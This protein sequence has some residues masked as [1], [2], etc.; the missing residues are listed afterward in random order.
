MATTTLT[1]R[2]ALAGAEDLNWDDKGDGGSA[3]VSNSD[4]SYRTI[5]R[6]NASHLPVTAATRAKTTADGTTMTSGDVDTALQEIYDDLAAIGIPD[7]TILEVASG[8]LQIAANSIT[9]TQLAVECI[10]SDQY[11]D[12]SI[13]TAHFAAGAV[14][15]T[16]LG[17]NAVTNTKIA[18]GAVD[19]DE[20]AAGAVTKDKIAD[21]AVD[22]DSLDM[23]GNG[24]APSHYVVACEEIAS[25]T[26]ST[27]LAFTTAAT[28]QSSDIFLVTVKSFGTGPNYVK[29][30]NYT[31]V[32]SFT[33]DV[34][35]AQSAGSTTVQVQVLRATSV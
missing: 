25:S 22:I 23:D 35:T 29:T 27:A 18:T 12:G 15:E 33:V 16:A 34:D 21:N 1:V 24:A 13:D 5:T 30:V 11:V 28:L 32:N 2:K 9:T 4:G 3:V 7:G 20:L 14:D 19:T 26:A 8:T 6:I 31:G 17:T 10:D